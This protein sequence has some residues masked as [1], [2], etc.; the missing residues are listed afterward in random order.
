MSN[1]LTQ[2]PMGVARDLYYIPN[3][4]VDAS[5][6]YTKVDERLSSRGRWTVNYRIV[7]CDKSGKHYDF[8]WS[9]GATEMQ[10]DSMWGDTVDVRPVVSYTFTETRWKAAE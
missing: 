4:Q 9:D 10:E 8:L 2:I 7:F 5:G 3:D 1:V 6:K